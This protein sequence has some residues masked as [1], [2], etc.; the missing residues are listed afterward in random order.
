MLLWMGAWKRLGN[1]WELGGGAVRAGF[2][3]AG[4]WSWWERSRS[5]GAGPD[6]GSASCSA[7]SPGTT[8]PGPTGTGSDAAASPG[9]A[10]DTD[11]GAH[12]ASTGEYSKCCQVYTG[13]T[14][15]AAAQPPAS[16]PVLINGLINGLTTR[17]ISEL[18]VPVQARTGAAPS[19]RQRYGTP[20]T[21]PP[22][23]VTGCGQP[24]AAERGA[25]AVAT[26]PVTPSLRAPRRK[27]RGAGSVIGGEE[28]AAAGGR[29]RVPRWR[30]RV[31]VRAAPGPASVCRGRGGYPGRAGPERGGDGPGGCDGPGVGAAG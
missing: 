15:G 16:L 17:S 22:L 31:R 8:S 9:G 21:S 18:P 5:P 25:V 19:V 11:P 7:S 14:N 4:L 6:P 13:V 1:R 10:A 28:A 23:P 29:V 20:A 12:P 26:R 24:A 3:P 2:H 27:R 30:M